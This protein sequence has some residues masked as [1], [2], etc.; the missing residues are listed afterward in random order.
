MATNP[1]PPQERHQLPVDAAHAATVS[2]ALRLEA[3]ERAER[4]ELEAHEPECTCEQT[5][6]DL[7]DAR[8]CEYHDAD[9]SWNIA[10]RALGTVERFEVYEPAA[11][12]ECPF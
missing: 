10:C 2:Q 3:L 11:A 5:D 12:Q 4:I 6:V 1:R 9:S 8:G 7:F